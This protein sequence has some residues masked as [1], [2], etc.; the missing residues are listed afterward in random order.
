MTHLSR[1]L[2]TPDGTFDY[3][4]AW[5]YDAACH[6]TV[7]LACNRRRRFVFETRCDSFAHAIEH[8]GAT[9][10][11][12]GMSLALKGFTPGANW[13]DSAPD[14]ETLRLPDGRLIHALSLD[15]AADPVSDLDGAMH[16]APAPVREEA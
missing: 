4:A 8:L 10:S 16:T 2:D 3:N 11:R 6:L 5:R 15:T 9:L 1:T 13:I 12:R 7:R 14:C